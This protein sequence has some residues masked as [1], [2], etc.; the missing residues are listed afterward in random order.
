[1]SAYSPFKLFEKKLEQ[2]ADMQI[3][4]YNTFIKILP[5]FLNSELRRM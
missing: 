1:M 3:C 5:A 2:K 4:F